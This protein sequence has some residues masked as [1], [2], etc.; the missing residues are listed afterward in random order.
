MEPQTTGTAEALALNTLTKENGS[1]NDKSH[2]DIEG[3]TE[4]QYP[5]RANEDASP[6]S[7]PP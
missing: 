6:K 1:I 4:G 3:V 5:N 2:C 7:L